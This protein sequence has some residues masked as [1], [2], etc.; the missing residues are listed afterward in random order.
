M[1]SN[2]SILSKILFSLTSIKQ[3]FWQSLQLGIKILGKT[4]DI[5]SEHFL[6]L[7]LETKI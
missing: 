6:K 1:K 5:H 2:V 3:G 4:L 7:S